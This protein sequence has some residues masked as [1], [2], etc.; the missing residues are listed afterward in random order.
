MRA[1]WAE[2]DPATLAKPATLSIV[3]GPGQSRFV[4]ERTIGCET[5]ALYDG[6]SG[7]EARRW[8]E[9]VSSHQEPGTMRFLQN[10]VCRSVYP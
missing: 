10:G 2:P 6:P 8:W 1:A 9:W 3:V 5:T 4:V 7:A